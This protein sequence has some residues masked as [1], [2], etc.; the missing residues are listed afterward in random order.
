MFW[1]SNNS[2]SQPDAPTPPAASEPR[3]NATRSNAV[4]TMHYM[5]VLDRSSSMAGRIDEV[6]SVVNQQ[7]QQ[8][9]LEAK[10]EANRCLVSL[11]RFDH[12]VEVVH[13]E[14]P[15][16]E[17]EPLSHEDLAPRGS[18]ALIDA[19]VLTI[20]QAA[21]LLG[22]KVDGNHES[23]AIVVYT[24]GEE[25]SSRMRNEADLKRV[26]AEH[27]DKPGW[28]IAFVGASPEAFTTMQRA[29]FQPDKM[30]SIDVED[31][32]WAMAEMT[33]M[34]QS[35]MSLNKAFSLCDMQ[36]EADRRSRR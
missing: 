18:T 14:K 7:L 15:I 25:N 5:L 30:V 24:D 23:V 2:A 4:N 33:R 35:K 20:E 21:L 31:S 19:T 22:A 11:V 6:R 16:E 32:G 17:I 12:E 27:Q 9:A 34:L 28:D 3:A 29:H 13:F 8:L 26:L 1:F 10:R 36:E